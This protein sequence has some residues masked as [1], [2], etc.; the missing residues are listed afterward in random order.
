MAEIF[1]GEVAVGV[2]PDARGWETKLRSQ[3]VPSSNNIGRERPTPRERETSQ[4]GHLP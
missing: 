2:V 3:L 4:P 1:V